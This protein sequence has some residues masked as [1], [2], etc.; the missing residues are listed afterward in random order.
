[1]NPSDAPEMQS[2]PSPNA[3]AADSAGPFYASSSTHPQPGM[4]NPD[5]LQLTA[6]ITRTLAPTMNTS[7]SETMQ[8]EQGQ[9]NQG[10]ISHQYEQ[11]HQ[12]HQ[13]HPGPLQSPTM[14]MD[15]MGGQY[16]T[17]DGSGGQ[18]KR[19]KVSRAC[20]ECRRKK[21][22]CD[23]D[24]EP[25]HEN[26]SNCRRVGSRCQF[27]RVP[28]KRGP[29]KGYVCS[30]RFG[31]LSSYAPAFLGHFPVLLSPFWSTF[32]VCSCPFS[33][34]FFCHEGPDCL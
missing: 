31:L 14:Q 29:S 20:D 34:S 9:P 22:R 17:P 19:S 11:A 7:A 3:I 1:M 24:G 18:R 30:R 2:Y 8:E 15:D 28:M 32:L 26:C 33:H 13:T 25:G 10:I 6:R 16:G 5:E 23:A 21:I 27:S 12:A 4:P